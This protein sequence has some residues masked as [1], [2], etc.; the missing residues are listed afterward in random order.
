MTAT[1]NHVQRRSHTASEDP[2]ERLGLA[3]VLAVIALFV[4]FSFLVA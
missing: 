1:P 3:I 2:D 4:L